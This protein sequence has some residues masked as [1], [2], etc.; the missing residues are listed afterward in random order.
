MASL[1]ISPDRQTADRAFAEMTE[2][3]RFAVPSADP[4]RGYRGDAST[5]LNHIKIEARAGLAGMRHDEDE[6]FYSA[7]HR[8]LDTDDRRRITTLWREARAH[9]VPAA[10][11]SRYDDLVKDNA[12]VLALLIRSRAN[13][14]GMFWTVA[15]YL[16]DR[17]YGGPEEGGWWYDCG[18]LCDARVIE[19]G[20]HGV[21][22]SFASES[23]AF[24]W[25]RAVN[26]TLDATINQGRRDIGSVLSEGRYVAQ[27]CPGWPEPHYPKVR[28]HYE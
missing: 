24:A 17:S 18:T 16:A 21:P 4:L 15:I 23:A 22:R 9:S 10:Y 26:E 8:D 2:A 3:S 1:P 5:L 12:T 27:V 7:R 13:R 28:P 25:C 14:R 19:A 20:D 6:P 11:L